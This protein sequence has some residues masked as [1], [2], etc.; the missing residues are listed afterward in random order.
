MDD[1]PH[2]AWPIRVN[3]VA[4]ATCQQDSTDE[5]AANVAT[6]VC[7]ERGSRVEAPDFGITD[8]TFAVMPID[9]TEIEQQIADYEPRARLDIE[10]TDDG[11]GGQRVSIAVYAQEMV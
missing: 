1:V 7:F 11:S 3:G 6:L 9:V 10:L 4:Y 2:I 5:L 8:P